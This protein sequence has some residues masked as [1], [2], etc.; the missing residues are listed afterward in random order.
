MAKILLI[1]GNLLLFRT[2]Y[3][4]YAGNPNPGNLPAHLF[5]K[6]VLD[7]LDQHQPQYVFVAFDA[8]GPTKRHLLFADY[9]AGRT[10]PPAA[11]FEQKA[12]ILTLLKLAKIQAY[13]QSGDEA[14]DLIATLTRRYHHHHQILIVSEDKDLLQLVGP[15][16]GVLIKN[17]ADKRAYLTIEFNNFYQH[18][19]LQPNQVVDFKAIAGD[20]SDNLRG[21]KGIGPKT[22]LKLIE[23]YG[24]LE[25]I[26]DHL[27]EI[28]PGI[29]TKLLAGQKEAFL[30]KQLAQLNE[31]AT[32]A[33]EL[34]DL[35]FT[36][37]QLQNT[38]FLAQLKALNLNRLHAILT[39]SNS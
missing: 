16:V 22:A 3:A 26:Y 21:V 38:T 28:A 23:Q 7:A 19:Q 2:F 36:W 4:A 9:K 39:N 30:C 34:D 10:A 6:S 5:F 32:I 12:I 31:Q 33:L 18:F 8:P 1:D 17:K 14:D 11:I 24:N 15:N 35:K 13:E 20:S 37:L 29:R 25:A 27:Y